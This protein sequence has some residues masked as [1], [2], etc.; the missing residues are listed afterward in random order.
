MSMF[1]ICCLLIFCF[2][3][4]P[5]LWA[6][7]NDLTWH[8]LSTKHG[9]SEA[10]NAFVFKDS[11]G[12]VWISSVSGLNRFDGMG[13][14]VY[15]PDKSDPAS[16]VNENIQSSFFEDGQHNIWF[17]T[18][19]GLQ[20]YN[21]NSDCF[22]HYQ[23]PERTVTEHVGYYAFFLDP[24][25]YLWL[26]VEYQSLYTF[27]IPTGTFQ[28][29]GQWQPNSI[30]CS[31]VEDEN[32][33]LR[34]ILIRGRDWPGIQVVDV[35]RDHKTSD[36]Y[37][38]DS[39]DELMLTSSRPIIPS[40]DS[41]Y[42][43]LRANSIIRYAVKTKEITSFPHPEEMECMTRANDTTLLIGTSRTGLLVFNTS[44][45]Q[46]ISQG[47]LNGPMSSFGHFHRIK[48]INMDRDGNIWTS[49]EGIGLS[50]AQPKK[51]KFTTIR[52]SD[53]VPENYEVKPIG[54]FEIGRDSMLCFSENDG[55]FLIIG[56]PPT[57][58]ILPY[59]PLTS[60]LGKRIISVCKDV[61]NNYWINTW[62]GIYIYKPD[63]Q[64]IIQVTNDSNIGS[65][66]FASE[67]GRVYYTHFNTGVS[68]CQFEHGRPV[69]NRLDKKFE[70]LSYF[71]VFI[72]H[73][74]RLWLGQ[75]VKTF[76]V[77]DPETFNEIAA[78][79]FTG[80]PRAI[81]QSKDNTSIYIGTY[82]GFFE[83]DEATLQL[84]HYHSEQS[85]FPASS[86]F[87]LLADSK[88][89]IWMGHSK[90]IARY[91]PITGQTQAY[92]HEDGL[93][94]SS[95]TQAACTLSGGQFCFGAIGGITF[96]DPEQIHPIQ[97][98]AQ[99]QF[100]SLQLND[101]LPERQLKC[102]KTGVTHFEDMK[103]LC[104]PYR[105][106]NISFTIH[107]LEFSAPEANSISYTME[108]LDK[109]YLKGQNGDRIRYPSLP[110]GS[111]TFVMY[112]SN[113]DGIQ[114]PIPRTLEIIIMPPY[115]KT[116]WF[117]SLVALF[118][119]SI[120]G[121]IF[122][123]RFSKKL[124][125]Q[126]VRLKL[127]EN[128]HDD[129]GSRL[130]AIVLSA[131]D[132]EQNEKI[133]HPKIKSI[134]HIAKSIV[135][136]MRRLVWAIDPE[137]DNMSSIVQKINHDRSLILK[138]DIQFSIDV[139]ERLKNIVLPGE[140]RYQVCSICNESFNNI[141]KYAGATQVH[142]RIGKEHKL[143]RLSIMDNG[144]GFEVDAVKKNELTGSGYGLSNMHRRASRAGGQLQIHSAPGQGTRI[145][146]SFPFA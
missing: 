10:T 31:A 76:F 73:K 84:R 63:H 47:A 19:S 12:F 21:F 68:I 93:P 69:V 128:L 60:L 82:N 64:E 75:S 41:I 80:L 28:W 50:F 53:F 97:I 106:S 56:A 67:D 95:Y 15:L 54:L 89:A 113:S 126:R 14:R 115:Y 134:S 88:G 30:R 34:R 13:V 146:F 112:A 85:G 71:P 37:L 62:T 139:D 98:Q 86:I 57:T 145:E 42:W 61:E 38:L 117:I 32:G 138:E 109:D 137:N 70:D 79:P 26:L 108:G 58:T 78:I 114:N 49:T 144:K 90:G 39:R 25:M 87:S 44:Q 122:Y 143:I 9:L 16:L 140:L 110:P 99:P 29:R 18:Y 11:R 91:D 43:M 92:N 130:T 52:F 51:K 83:I 104:L 105:E 141:S 48:Y 65:S 94:L 24:E 20:K 101:K 59:A 120:M 4:H 27:H 46:F 22:D 6:Q 103:K 1:R 135:G 123:L 133:S 119:F 111:Y 35:T 136:N 77:Y 100:S 124:E 129:V 121:Y 72:D 17:T 132:L 55:A 36:P 96:F 7:V 131:E 118:C 2:M 74:N 66:I 81:L 33:F 5:A 142:I 102:E 107:S 23:V 8:S 40:G 116:W 45:R 127:Y 125:L 3:G